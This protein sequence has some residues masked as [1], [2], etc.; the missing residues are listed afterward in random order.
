MVL[1]LIKNEFKESQ[2]KFMPII[3]LIAMSSVVLGVMVKT[4]FQEMITLILL[5]VVF[6]L[7]VGSAVLSVMAFIDLLYTSL[8][9]K[10]G[11]RLFTYPVETWEILVSKVVVFILWYLI[12]G[13]VT[14]VSVGLLG[15]IV[16]SGT[17]VLKNFGSFLS[18]INT[19][20]ELRA[21]LTFGFYQ[22]SSL[23]FGAVFFLF[24]GSITNSAFIQNHRKFYT[25]ILYVI[26]LSISS[27]VFAK[28]VGNIG[29]LDISVNPGL[30][31]DG[32]P[33]FQLGMSWAEI[34]NITTNIKELQRLLLASLMTL[35]AS[36]IL[37]LGTLWFWNNKLEII[38]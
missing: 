27:N 16:F 12:I 3:G 20:I 25:F 1:K 23:I 18:Y 22:L 19:Q 7:G 10:N 4:N 37:T 26:L 8:Y 34:F 17:D 28:V 21:Y 2:S 29:G 15:L 33:Q 13:A 6:G 32:V 5:L 38:E 11:Y 30:F 31:I 14:I 36:G 9:N 35:A 24:I